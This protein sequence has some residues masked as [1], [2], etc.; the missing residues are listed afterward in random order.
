MNTVPEDIK[1]K[2]RLFAC[3]LFS[4]FLIP[5]MSSCGGNQ[6]GDMAPLQIGVQALKLVSPADDA[7]WEVRDILEH[8]GTVW[9]LTGSAPFVHGFTPG[10]ARVAAFGTA[11]E[12][13]GEF[14][15]PHGLWPGDSEGTLTVW[16]AGRSAALTVSS[17]G[18]LLASRPISDPGVIRSDIRTV[19]FG[20][21]FRVFKRHDAV[22]L[23]RYDSGVSSADDLWRGKL[24]RTSGHGQTAEEVVTDFARDLPGAAHR[25]GMPSVLTPVPLWDGCPDGQVAVL[26]PI[27]RTLYM[28]VPG[29]S[30]PDA[31]PLPWRPEELQ[32]VE[33]FRYLRHQIAA[34]LRNQDVPASEIDRIAKSVLTDAERMFPD[35]APIGVDLRC[36]RDRVWIQEFDGDSHPLG[37]GPRWRT[38]SRRGSGPRF[39]QV[40]FPA[41]FMPYRITDSRAVGVV[42]DN[43]ALQRLAT[44]DIFAASTR[45]AAG[46]LPSEKEIPG[47]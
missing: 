35:E 20:D 19:T 39:G 21:P 33:K 8:R 5:G 36:S 22:V 30:D 3:V 11:G 16:D 12:G 43:L 2:C 9:A 27:E 1:M 24:V 29:R 26:D 44:V 46:P 4:M 15:Y 25:P 28:L 45:V 6:S 34:E 13:P 40:A 7:L 18:K 10:G 42:T 23:G 38:V 14:R 31:I 37:Y 17:S 47:Q 41:G 32:R